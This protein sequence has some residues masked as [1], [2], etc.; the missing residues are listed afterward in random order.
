MRVTYDCQEADYVLLLRDGAHG[1]LREKK[2]ALLK[3]VKRDSYI[4][5]AL[6]TDG[7]NE[8]SFAPFPPDEIDFEQHFVCLAAT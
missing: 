1:C 2:H 3:V 8:F 6:S 5:Y 4:I 7:N